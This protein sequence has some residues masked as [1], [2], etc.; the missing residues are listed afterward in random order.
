MS[1]TQDTI[2][3]DTDIVTD[4]SRQR[5]TS[6][7]TQ[8][9]SK[10]MLTFIRPTNDAW[11]AILGISYLSASHLASEQALQASLEVLDQWT[12]NAMSVGGTFDLLLMQSIKNSVTILRQTWLEE[13]DKE[14]FE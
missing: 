13:N 9:F 6:Y 11:V 14:T 1:I 10:E 2:I 3:Q 12:T 8:S 5:I 7:F 4:D